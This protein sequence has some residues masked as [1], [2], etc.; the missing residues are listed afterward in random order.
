MDTEHHVTGHRTDG[1]V[2]VQGRV[3]KEAEVTKVRVLG[4]LVFVGSHQA[5]G[6][7]HG[8]VD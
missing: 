7:E 3:I 2:R 8:G 5:E 6:D 1:G 4:R